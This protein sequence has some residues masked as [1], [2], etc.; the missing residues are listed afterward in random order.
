MATGKIEKKLI[1]PSFEVDCES[2]P[3]PPGKKSRAKLWRGAGQ[4]PRLLIGR[5]L[6]GATILGALVVGVL[7]GRF[8]V[9]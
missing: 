2:V 7:I 4:D 6:F 8:L 9:P 1:S 3:I 5:L